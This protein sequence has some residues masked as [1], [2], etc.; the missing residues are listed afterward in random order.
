MATLFENG[1][2]SIREALSILSSLREG[3]GVENASVKRVLDVVWHIKEDEKDGLMVVEEYNLLSETL[4]E[5]S[6][7]ASR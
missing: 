6:K 2:I 7:N 5:V 4:R 1:A 3:E